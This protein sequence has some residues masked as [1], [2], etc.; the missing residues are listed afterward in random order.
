MEP[1]PLQAWCLFL[2][3]YAEVLSP[4]ASAGYPC[5]AGRQALTDF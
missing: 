5:L 4:S 3:A 1:T 2:P